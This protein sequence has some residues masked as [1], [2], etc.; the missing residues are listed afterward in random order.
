MEGVNDENNVKLLWCYKHALIAW[1]MILCFDGIVHLH[2][3]N[4][5]QGDFHKL[6]CC[7]RNCDEYRS[8]TTAEKFLPRSEDCFELQKFCHFMFAGSFPRLSLFLKKLQQIISA[9]VKNLEINLTFFL[10]D[11]VKIRP[12][13]FS[14]F[15]VFF[16][17][18][19]V[20]KENFWF[21][22]NKRTETK[23]KSNRK[24]M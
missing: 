5:I 11:Q 15:I 14:V 16:F 23:E 3:W 21:L 6:L 8:K 19:I 2:T 17:I 9:A 7:V 13:K 1:G 10:L 12:Q 4:Y 20:E 22:E 24:R 18:F